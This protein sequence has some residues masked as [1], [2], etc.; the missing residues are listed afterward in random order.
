MVSGR[1][2][3]TGREVLPS[4][5]WGG[6]SGPP[7]QP[8]DGSALEKSLQ[9][10]ILEDEHSSNYLLLDPVSWA[11]EAGRCLFPISYWHGLQSGQGRSPFMSTTSLQHSTTPG[12]GPHTVP[13]SLVA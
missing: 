8:L 10:A 5:W 9:D 12:S 2:R 6:E 13:H 4:H 3:H 11:P 7:H 1:A